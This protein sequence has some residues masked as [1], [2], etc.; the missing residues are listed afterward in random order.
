M[1]DSERPTYRVRDWTRHF[2]NAGS[3]KIRALSWVAIPNKHDSARY[4]R[5]MTLR[6]AISIY[7]AWLLIVQVAS[8]MPTRGTLANENGPLDAEDLSAWTGAPAKVFER[9]FQVLTDSKIGWLEKVANSTSGDAGSTLPER[10]DEV[11]PQD[12]TGPN[13]TGGSFAKRGVK[14]G[15]GDIHDADLCN[16]E[17]LAARFALRVQGGVIHG[18]ETDRLDYFSLAAKARRVYHRAPRP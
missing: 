6:D 7:G 5:V 1:S 16:P 8:K 13:R 12:R 15:V 18:A 9:A 14:G 4:R 2:E 17:W 11:S 3:R 10:P